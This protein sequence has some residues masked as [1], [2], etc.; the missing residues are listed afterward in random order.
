[1]PR[2]ALPPHGH[3]SAFQRKAADDAG[4][5]AD[6]GGSRIVSHVVCARVYILALGTTWLCTTPSLWVAS[7]RRMSVSGGYEH[8]DLSNVES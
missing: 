7:S 1:V 2:R 3:K 5:C 6:R 4:A 8:A